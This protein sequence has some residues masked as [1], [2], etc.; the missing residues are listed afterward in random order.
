DNEAKAKELK[1]KKSRTVAEKKN[2]MD[3]LARFDEENRRLENSKKSVAKR[4]YALRPTD[5]KVGDFGLLGAN[6]DVGQP[7]FFSVLQVIDKNNV[8]MIWGEK[9]YWVEM[10]TKGMVD[11]DK[12][13]MADFV[14]GVATKQYESASGKRTVLLLK[15]VK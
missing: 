11:D 2:Q 10:E 13:K 8:L 14:H 15:V 5:M 1:A 9:T 4:A 12:I 3:S 6:Y 7:P